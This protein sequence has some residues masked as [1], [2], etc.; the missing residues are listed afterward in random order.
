MDF[1]QL[2]ELALNHDLRIDEHESYRRSPPHYFNSLRHG[3]EAYFKTFQTNNHMYN[4]YAG[5]YNSFKNMMLQQAEIDEDNTVLC[6]IG[7][8]RF[9]ELFYKD[10]L[11]RTDPDLC[12][13]HN[14]S[15][16]GKEDLK[17]IINLIETNTFIPKQTNGETHIIPFGV[18]I[19]R[20]SAINILVQDTSNNS[21][22]YDKFR[23]VSKKYEFLTLPDTIGSM[24]ILNW[25]RNRILH[26]GNK[27]PWPWLLDYLV[28]Q[29][30]IPVICNV[31]DNEKDRVGRYLYFRKTQT[32]IDILNCFNSSGTRFAFEELK[33]SEPGT[34]MFDILLF[35]GH[36]KELGRA[37]LNMDLGVQQNRATHEYGYNDAKGRGIRFAKAEQ[38]NPEQKGYPDA[39]SINPCICCGV[40]SMVHYRIKR[41]YK[42]H[43]SYPDYIEWLKCYTC[44]YH[45]RSEAG[46]PSYFKLSLSRIFS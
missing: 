9:F 34:K 32:G 40:E 42:F 4:F 12:Y 3:F 35:F 44:D 1:K 39:Y 6:L 38:G 14:K 33:N 20:Y 8:A 30:F 11:S 19:D 24:K 5:G 25:Y 17:E 43:P 18:A 29:R 41:E 26:S 37:S 46:D 16:K 13:S 28:T 7:F 36:L 45:L 31:L 23:E 22:V 27:L 10:L 2:I 21:P 15:K